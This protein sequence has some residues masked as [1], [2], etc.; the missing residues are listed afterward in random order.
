MLEDTSI[1]VV[2]ITDR[3]D[4]PTQEDLIRLVANSAGI[5]RETAGDKI[6][7]IRDSGPTVDVP[8]VPGGDVQTGGEG[9]EE[10]QIPLLVWIALG[11]GI[12]LLL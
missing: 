2:I 4:S 1:G 12:I 11:A 8:V 6:T 9:D 10:T 5:P 7:L 3:L